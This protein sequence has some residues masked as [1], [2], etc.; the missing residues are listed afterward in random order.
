M[1]KYAKSQGLKIFFIT[2][3]GQIIS[4][5]GSELSGF[6][7]ALWVYQQT[8]AATQLVLV[9]FFASLSSVFISPIAGALVDRWERRWIMILSDSLG[10]LTTLSIALVIDTHTLKIWHIYLAT[11]IISTCGTFTYLAYSAS[12]TLLVPKHHLSRA[13]GMVHMGE[14]SAIM[15]GPMLAGVMVL[16]LGI[17]G[18]LLVDLT[19]FIFALATLS[20]V[21]FP[22]PATTTKSDLVKESLIR[23][24]FYGFSYIRRYP[25]LLGLLLF[26]TINN[27][28]SEIA[29]VLIT[30][31]LLSF[32]S[33]ADLGFTQ[34][35]CGIGML[36]GSIVMSIWGGPT[37]RIYGVFCFTI[38]QGLCILSSGL[39]PFVPLIA[40]AFFSH[41][42]CF[43]IIAGCSQVIWQSKVS[44]EI[45]GRVFAARRM[46]SWSS[47][48]LAYLLA[49]PIADYVF[50]PLL[51]TNGP[52]VN[53]V[54]IVI[55]VG[56]GR[57][58]GLL[59]V[60]LGIFTVLV[61]VGGYFYPALREV[62]TELP[63]V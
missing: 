43:P 34:S 11:F 15:I 46:I 32:A 38:L 53:S 12:I 1:A 14:A 59:F 47:L 63:D 27:F 35:F 7:L 28:F 33:S 57:G 56:K 42:F 54:G 4:L 31:M 36:L 19:T 6:S 55:G 21:H 37:Q 45:Q 13:S 17:H 22:K 20:R 50:E 30:P 60:V 3:F 29:K 23:D 24:A 26:F 44:P 41:F 62:E 25:S 58:I 8:Q 61:V 18:V 10:A 40:V 9:S 51:A 2:W 49:G 16:K 52:L 5:I 48:P 39:R